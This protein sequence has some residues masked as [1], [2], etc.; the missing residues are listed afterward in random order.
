MLEFLRPPSHLIAYGRQGKGEVI[1]VNEGGLVF[2]QNG[3]M[4]RCF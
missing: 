2:V 3:S 1:S 4:T